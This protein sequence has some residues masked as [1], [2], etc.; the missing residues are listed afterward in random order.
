MKKMSEVFELPLAGE[1]NQGEP[2]LADSTCYFAS[3][4]D[5][6]TFEDGRGLER[7]QHAAH[8][9]NHV[10]ALAEAL[11]KLLSMLETEGRQDT[12]IF[13]ECEKASNAYWGIK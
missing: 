12:E 9:I 1:E 11:D 5:E 7:A 13:K 4:D 6:L 8:A 3:F 10:D 2:F